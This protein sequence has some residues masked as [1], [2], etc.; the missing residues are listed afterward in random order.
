[1]DIVD[2]NRAIHYNKIWHTEFKWIMRFVF[3]EKL[4]NDV[5]IAKMGDRMFLINNIGDFVSAIDDV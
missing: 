3:S 1:M 5:A 2:V 4:N